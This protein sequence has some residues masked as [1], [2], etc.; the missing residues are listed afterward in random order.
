MNGQYLCNRA[1]SVSYAFK[2]D[3][4]GERHGSAAERLLAAQNPL[5][6]ADRPHQIFAD[7]PAVPAQSMPGM[8]GM[9]LP[10]PPPP[11]MLAPPGSQ[12]PGMPPPPPPV[13][14]PLPGMGMGIVYGYGAGRMGEGEA[15]DVSRTSEVQASAICRGAT[16]QAQGFM[17]A[18]MQS[19]S[20]A[21]F[22]NEKMYS[23]KNCY[24][25]CELGHFRSP[26]HYF[27]ANL[28]NYWL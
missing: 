22:E 6:Q 28:Q 18:Q 9:P 27:R 5:S 4:K 2:K 19:D 10:P 17:C 23:Q 15:V 3:S 11:G 20:V 14:L 7:A 13:P 25:F 8:P 12:P 26:L 1:I 16:G 24:Y 21:L